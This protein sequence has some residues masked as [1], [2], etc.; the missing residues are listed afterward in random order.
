MQ[1]YSVQ[2]IRAWDSYTIDHEPIRSIDLMERASQAFVDWFTEAYPEESGTI[3]ILCGM[4]NNGGDGWAIGRLL[5][6]NGYTVQIWDCQLSAQRS[7][8][9]KINAERF[10]QYAYGPIYRVLEEDPYP[11]LHPESVLIDALFGSGLSRP[12]SGYW[13][14]LITWIN[15][16]P[17][18][19]IA[20]DVPSGLFADQI[21][22]GSILKAHH[23]LSFQVPKLGFMFSEHGPCLGDWQILDIELHSDFV[24]ENPSFYQLVDLD[25]C[26]NIYRPR[27]RFGHKGTFGHALL[28]VGSRGMMGAGV[29]ATQAC[30]SGGCGLV[31]AHI[32][33]QGELIMQISFP[34]AVLSLDPANDWISVLPN[35]ARYQAIG[36]GCGI[37]K[38]EESAQVL[39]E[40]IQKTQVPL[41]LDADALNILSEHPSWITELPPHT[42][43]TPHPKEFARLFGATK[44]SLEQLDRLR[45]AAQETS[46]VILLKGAFSRI[47]L[48]NGQIFFNSTGNPGMGTGGSGD[49]LTGLLT[50]LLAQGYP[51]EEAAILGTFLHGR[52]GDLA[53]EV[54]GQEALLASDLV[55]QMGPAFLSLLRD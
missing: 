53:A 18:T 24:G 15:E 2:Q 1:I 40:L 19:R 10:V 44:D 45:A 49:V 37:G 41:V 31:T 54:V 8:D 20:V 25:I 6:E 4:G 5:S 13:G 48:P 12:I 23:T 34:E 39:L 55:D 7:P 32:P 38:R 29:L 43:L 50:G 51:P 22:G 30:L 21:S 52:A 9:N 36:I 33:A 46:C 42:I 3:T 28:L 47:A 27:P 17:I 16:Q 14:G 11:L 26:Q 35:L